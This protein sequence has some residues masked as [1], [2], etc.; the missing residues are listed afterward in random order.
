MRLTMVHSSHV[1]LG[2]SLLSDSSLSCS[3]GR[4]SSLR[5]QVVLIGLPSLA[6]ALSQFP[7][8]AIYS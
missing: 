8:T 1:T 3:S 4:F 6:G 5:V 2:S 7:V